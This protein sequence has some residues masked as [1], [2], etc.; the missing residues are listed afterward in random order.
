MDDVDTLSACWQF[1]WAEMRVYG[2]GGRFGA[3]GLWI[4]IVRWGKGN[5]Q[6]CRAGGSVAGQE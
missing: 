6:K 2:H 4:D 5:E 1:S 3:V